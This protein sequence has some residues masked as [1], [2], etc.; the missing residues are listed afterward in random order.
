MKFYDRR[1]AGQ[2]LAKVISQKF[3]QIKNGIILA[4]PRGGVVVGSEVAIDLNLPLDIVVTRKIGAPLNSE[5][6]IAAVSSHK[7]ILNKREVIDQEYL[8]KQTFQERQEI[9][10]RMGEYRGHR[11]YPQLAGK[12][13]ILV[14][15][16][17]ATGLTMKAAIEE[18]KLHK[19]AKIILAVPVAPPET[20]AELKKMVDATVIL[21]EEP[22]FFAVGQFYEHFQQTSDREVKDLLG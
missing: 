22:I 6:A 20:V 14:D 7:I 13:I 18:I 21:Y 3:P 17:L 1:Q 10:R 16:G 15:D 12:T 8:K 4:L 5:Y 19:P 11:P 2:K 9:L